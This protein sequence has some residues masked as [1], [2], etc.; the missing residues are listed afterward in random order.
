MAPMD[1]EC[2]APLGNTTPTPRRINASK[3]WCFTLNNYNQEDIDHLN[4]HGSDVSDFLIFSEEVG[5]SGTPHLQGYI[6]FKKK[7]RPME[8]FNNKRFHWEKSKGSQ[9]QNKDY[10][11]K[12]DGNVYVNGKRWVEDNRPLSLIAFEE[13]LHKICNIKNIHF[14]TWDEANRFCGR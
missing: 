5:E 9:I 8:H 4:S 1:P 14:D 11:T 6:E 10:I 2:A 3:R 13:A 12:A 7:T